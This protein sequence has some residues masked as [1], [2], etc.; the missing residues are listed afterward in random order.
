MDIFAS[1][2]KSLILLLSII[3]QDTAPI[4]NINLSY[5]LNFVDEISKLMDDGEFDGLLEQIY[6]NLIYA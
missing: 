2:S 5:P 1:V 4:M 3:V 6:M